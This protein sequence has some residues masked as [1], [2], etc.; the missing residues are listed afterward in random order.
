MTVF[1]EQQMQLALGLM[2]GLD[3][4]NAGSFEREQ[5]QQILDHIRAKTAA[6]D[7]EGI[8]YSQKVKDTLA[9]LDTA[10]ADSKMVGER[11]YHEVL[12]GTPDDPN[13]PENEYVAPPV[14]NY[15]ERETDLMSNYYAPVQG[16]Y[17]NAL[18]QQGTAYGNLASGYDTRFTEGMGLLDDYGTQM[19]NDVTNRY[20]Q[21]L[22]RNTND[23]AQ[24][25]L[26]NTTIGA[27]LGNQSLQQANEE[28]RRVGEGITGAKTNL[29]SQLS[30]DALQSKER[31]ITANTELGLQGL[32]Y[33]ERLGQYKQALSGEPLAVMERRTDT[34]PDEGYLLQ[35]YSQLGQGQAAPTSQ[36]GSS[37]FFQQPTQGQTNTSGLFG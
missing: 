4:A 16:G 15:G 3:W 1:D 23:L 9:K 32:G 27:N 12:G 33:D 7:A 2:T 10:V 8:E 34:G 20:S 13:T 35:A 36:F 37:S 18:S 6:A 28:Y 14:K 26:N 17:A 25:G 19:N 22:S 21:A 30:G 11:R 31:G 29:W 24:R 5:V